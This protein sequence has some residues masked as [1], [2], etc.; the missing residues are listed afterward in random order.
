MS[1]ALGLLMVRS[2]LADGPEQQMLV[3]ERKTPLSFPDHDWT[4]ND[5]R[6][7]V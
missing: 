7:S 2:P 1:F 5:A 6:N 4:L 3:A